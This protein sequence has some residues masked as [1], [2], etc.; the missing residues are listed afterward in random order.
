[1]VAI[2]TLSFDIAG[3]EIFGPLVCGAKLVL[4]SR[5]QVLD[6][7]LLACLLNESKATVMQATPSTWR[8]LVEAGW[9]GRANLRMWC[10]GEALRP[11]LAESLLTR[12]RELWNLYGPT[13][14]T[15]WS[16]AHRIKSGE[17]PIL[18]G[19][20][21]G[22]TRM[23]ILDPN[24]QPAPI[25]VS[26]ELYI[27]GAGVARGYRKQ[28]ALTEAR[29]VSDPFD[30]I[31]GRRMYRTGDLARYRRDG[32]IQLIGRT[33]HQIKLR[34]HRIELGE[35][36]AVIERHPDVLQ[37]VVALQGEGSGQQLIAYIKQSN[38]DEDAGYLRPWLQERL[39]EYMVPSAFTSLAEIPLTPNGKVDRKQLPKPKAS[40]REGSAP[41]APPRNRLEEQ[42]AQIW[43]EILGLDRVGIRD[44]F[45]DLGGHSLL[46]IRVHARLRKELDS[47]IAVIDHFR[48]PTIESMASWL[49]HRRHSSIAPAGANS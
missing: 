16:A 2:T 9:M 7:E 34:G 41:A 10:G 21:I 18:I 20:P 43:S 33:D 38:S 14:T 25:G 12:G 47:D 37:A 8:M 5:E 35:I 11:D 31:A 36:E 1:L 39:P 22:N 32:Q 24:G 49:E 29:F 19:R 28:T 45:F 46:L 17:N 30:P 13:E 44:N 4:A 40:T 6:P 23:Y 3:L 48:Y 27:A 15:I 42:L 26:G